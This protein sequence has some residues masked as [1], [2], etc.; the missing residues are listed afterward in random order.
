VMQEPD[1]D[2][3]KKVL[4][5]MGQQFKLMANYPDDPRLN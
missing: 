5:K 4:S 1:S 3:W 2:L